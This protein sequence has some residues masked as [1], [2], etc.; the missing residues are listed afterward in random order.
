MTTVVIMPGGF[1]PFHA[2]HLALYQSAQRAF[3][4]AEV[5]VAATNDTSSRPF[6]F[7]VKEKLAKLAGVEPG[8]FVQ[9]KSP[10]RAEEITSRFDPDQDVL[11]FVRS[12]KDAG[13]PPQPG[14]VKKDGSATYLQPLLGAQKLE[15]FA[16]HA[17]M[18]YLP[19][20]EFGPGMTSAT[21]IRTAWPT[22]N[23]KR[24]TAL[25][26]SLYPAAQKNTKLAATVVKLL[27][28]AIGGEQGVA[29]GLDEAVGGNYLYHATSAG[30]LKGMLS[31]GSIKAANAPQG[32]TAAQTQLPTVSLTRDWGYASG[33]N[34]GNQMAGIGRDVVIVLDRNTVESNFKTLGTS[35]STNIKG[36]AFNPYLKK[37]GAARSQNTDPMAR[38][39]AKAKAKYA[40]PTA[41][42]GGEFEEAVVVP[43]GA[44]PLKGTMV[45]FWV[46]PKSE[47][48]KDPAIMN[49]PRRLDM[50]RP[51][52]FVKATQPQ[53][54]AEGVNDYLWHGSRHKNKVLVP[55]QANDTGGK[56]ESNKNAI[57]ATPNAKVAIAM[58][59]TTSGSDTGMF[60]NDPQMV[61][62]KGGIRKGEMVYLHKV[63]KDLFIKHNG[64]E[65][66]SKPDVKEIT[67]PNENIIAVPVD[68]YL[69]LIRQATPA[70]LE[71]QKKHMKKGMAETSLEDRLKKYVR[72]V[73]KTTPKIERTT[74]PAGRTT[75]HVEWKVTGPMGDVN[76]FSSKKAAQ[77][78]YDSFSKPGADSLKEFAPGDGDDGENP[79]DDYPCYDCGSTI[80]LH[81]T[82]LCDLA[83][84]DAVRDLPAQPG[85]QHWTGRVPKGLTPIPG[86]GKG[87]EETVSANG[88][89][90]NTSGAGAGMTASYQRRDNQPIDEDYLEERRL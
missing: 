72:P 77:A 45:G 69:N 32:A 11:I 67:V 4:D 62:F 8:H 31:S 39:N 68:K 89:I 35:Q 53:G 24:K 43:K 74:N 15:P 66:Y 71:L 34:A 44:L 58:G 5:F 26:M 84:P 85:T 57:Y 33:S 81:H 52:Q 6:P 27:D 22:L 90:A 37:D 56:E 60:P 65:W 23:E 49:D 87:V 47:L 1:H 64:R 40:E 46:N 83:E 16:Q 10:F 61:L 12:E 88:T 63:P 82:R 25:V 29:E 17:Y 54:V 36:L 76:R 14:G 3:P 7:A 30:G 9:V 2:G 86:L 79:L 21:E 73:V 19:T 75:D 38:A 48:M 78:H 51:N 50:V 80:Y 42:A 59:L 20:V 18:A 41:K 55:R 13:S 70:D 28:A